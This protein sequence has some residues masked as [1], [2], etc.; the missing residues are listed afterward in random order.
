MDSTKKRLYEIGYIIV[1][2]TFL[3]TN[4][5]IFAV[6]VLLYFF[7]DKQSALFIGTL[8]FLNVALWIIQDLRAWYALEKL[9]SLTAPKVSRLN[10]DGTEEVVLAEDIKKGDSIKLKIGDQVPVDCSFV[11]GENLE[12]NEGLITGESTSIVKMPG[13]IILAGSIVTTGFGVV[14]SETIFTE[15][16]IAR[17]TAGIKTYSKTTSPI[18]KSVGTI[19][20]Y[21]AYMSIA[22][23]IYTVVHGNYVGE[24]PVRIVKVIGSIVS[25]FVPQGMV[26]SVTLFFTYGAAN[27]FKKQVLLQEVNATEKL[28]RIKNLCMDKTGTLT[29]KEILMEK[30]YISPKIEKSR[31]EIMIAGYLYGV[32]DSSSEIMHALKNFFTTL[33]TGEILEILP[34]SSWRKYGAIKMKNRD[35]EYVVL[36]GLPDNFLEHITDSEEH[37]WLKKNLDMESNLG[38]RVFCFVIS[39]EKAIPLTLSSSNL[40]IIAMATFSNVLREGIAET[41]HFFQERDVHIRIISG[42]NLQTSQAIALAAGINN[43]DKSISGKEI[44]EWSDA[45][46][47]EKVHNYTVF[48]QIVPEQKEK[49]VEAF[50]E[51]GFTAMIGDGANDALAIKKADLGIAMFDGSPATRHVAS[52]VLTNNSFAALP[53]GVI[54]AGTIIRN[55][56]VF[57]S[58]F[59]NLMFSGVFLFIILALFGYE[60]PITPLNITFINYF[61]IGVPGILLSYWTIHPQSILLQNDTRSFLEKVLSFSVLAAFFQACGIAIIFALN[62]ESARTAETNTFVVLGFILFGFVFFLFSSRLYLGI[63]DWSHKLQIFIAGITSILLIVAFFYIPFL[64]KFYN[65]VALKSNLSLIYQTALISICI[66]AIQ[67]FLMQ[68]FMK[69]VAK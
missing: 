4:G 56:E 28:G 11:E 26:F 25:M 62:E 53:D 39:H 66:C 3:L 16:R 29:K 19:V 57:G 51:N 6:V 10:T 42:D 12:V 9:Q 24:S 8:L 69:K 50:K 41:V 44:G 46:F 22:A 47:K 38:K 31:A 34:F 40:S 52:I 1:K 55:I 21:S 48:A 33:F 43:S 68:I 60:Y 45:D 7:N 64:M 15:S 49:I 18:Q 35:E 37:T 5:L 36:A 14:T 65:V 58:I 54:L 67:Y 20:T 2:N 30:I 17:M 61:A 13:D 23:V 32:K 27:L 59:F 63:M